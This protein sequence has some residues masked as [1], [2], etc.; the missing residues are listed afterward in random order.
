MK[1]KSLVY[2]EEVFRN[3]KKIND[4]L[5]DN[6]LEWLIDAE[7]EN[8]E[9]EIKNNTLIWKNGIWYSGTWHYGIWL[10]GSFINGT[11]ENGIWENGHFHQTAKFISGIKPD[12]KIIK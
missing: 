2:K 10:D 3:S 4:I 5:L 7:I 6:N 8:A 11:W 12:K 1:Y 9:L